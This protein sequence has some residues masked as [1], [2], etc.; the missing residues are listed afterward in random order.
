MV[1]L[2]L[3]LAK[4]MVIYCFCVYI[5]TQT[6]SLRF[7]CCFRT[8]LSAVNVTSKRKER[9]N[10]A[11]SKG[12]TPESEATCQK[13]Q[14]RQ[15][16]NKWEFARSQTIDNRISLSSSVSNVAIVVAVVSFRVAHAKRAATQTHTLLFIQATNRACQKTTT[17]IFVSR[18]HRKTNKSESPCI[19]R[20]R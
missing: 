6:S 2:C 19:A 3:C 1:C 14:E 16:R 15:Q 9:Y 13:K 18:A 10:H 11:K 7:S 20:Y 12:I 4:S 17:T 5:F 8:I